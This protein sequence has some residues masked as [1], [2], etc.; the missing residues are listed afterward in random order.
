MQDLVTAFAEIRP[1]AAGALT[2]LLSA[3]A[4][5]HVVLYKR[6]SRAAGAALQRPGRWPGTTLEMERPPT[7][8]SEQL[9]PAGLEG[10]H[11]LAE[12]VDR[13]TGRQVT[14]GNT[15]TP[16]EQGDAA[17]PAM[18]AAIEGA[19]V[20]VG[21]STNIFDHDFA[22]RLFMEALGAAARRGVATRVLIDDVGARYSWPPIVHRLRARG[23]TVGRFGRTVLPWRLPYMNLRNHRKLLVV[24][25]RIGF[26]GGM[27]IRDGH[28]LERHPRH[29]V[30]DLHFRL[31]GPVVRH[32]AQA[33]ADDWQFTTGE[34]LDGDAWFP[35]LEPQGPVQA[36]GIT[37]GPDEDFEKAR[38][39][40]LGALAC[41][42]TSVQIVTPYFLPDSGLI[43]A[44]TVAAMRGV[45]VD[46][47][48]PAVN[49]QAL[50]HWAAT[51]QLWQVVK[52][53]CRVYYGPPPFDHTKLM[54]VDRGWALI[55]SSNWDP[56]SLRLNFEFDVEC[57]DER[58][59]DSLSH[60]VERKLAA[61]R[62]I[63]AHDLD[64]RSLPVRLRDGI[65][66]LA[67]PYL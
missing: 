58:L 18:L 66:R 4:S 43:T 50:V 53:G 6:D 10:L 63:S 52:R 2:I 34:S 19:R 16:L 29:P 8:R 28:L 12:L 22:G 56:R 13:V 21:L 54:V 64:N 11:S 39:V 30:Q 15:V 40:V 17:Y 55:G 42:H 37:D 61:A 7:L 49:N 24:D 27:N 23:V 46:I 57:Y 36:R 67:A 62:E 51:A 32:L 48:L 9:L 3:L 1:I 38:L 45:Q 35:R 41:A 25:G 14:A 47:V 33:F 5:G 20:S 59:A 65:A 31:E 60:L 26:T 44:L